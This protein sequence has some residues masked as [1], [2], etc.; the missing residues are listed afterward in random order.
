MITDLYSQCIA[1]GVSFEILTADD[2]STDMETLNANVSALSNLDHC[3]MIS[4]ERNYGRAAIRNLLADKSS[5]EKLLFIDC[6]AEVCTKNFITDYIR[7]SEQS[8]V[9]CGGLK[10]CHRL[11]HDGVELRWK[12]EKRAD[13]HRAARYRSLNPYARFTPFSFLIDRK[14]FMKIRFDEGFSGY[15]YEDVLFGI[16]LEKKGISV[17]HIDNP[18]IHTGLED[19]ETF[20]RK[21]DEAIRNLYLHR[22]ELEKGSALL[23]HYQRLERLN[24]I[25]AFTRLTEW[26][27][28][29]IIINLAGKHPSLLFFSAYKML[30]LC[31]LFKNEQ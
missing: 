11:P 4:V 12:Y 22:A 26:F 5:C 8:E 25:N 9:V 3:R 19:N 16:E 6:D 29:P 15:G 21:T 2:C 24:L 30:S 17:L 23:R 14:V 1:A 31:R 28:R 18:L 13:R 20:L 27:Y 7:A 10:H